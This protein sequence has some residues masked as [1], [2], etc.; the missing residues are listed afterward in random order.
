MSFQK[1]SGWYCQF[2][3]EDLKTPLAKTLSLVNQ[4]KLFEIAQRGGYTLNRE[5]RQALPHAIEIG[6]GGIWLELTDEQYRR[7]TGDLQLPLPDQVFPTGI[8]VSLHFIGRTSAIALP[9]RHG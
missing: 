7:L 6:R 3:E 4:N 8:T 1:Q 5:G 2:L 9:L